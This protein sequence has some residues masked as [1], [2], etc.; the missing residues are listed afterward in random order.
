[1]PLVVLI[2]VSQDQAQELARTLVRERLAGC[3][4]VIP[5]SFSVYRWEGE[6][7]EDTEALL[8]VKT[9][10]GAYPALEARVRELHSYQ[11]PELLALNVDQTPTTF[12]AWLENNVRG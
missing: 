1:M 2:P 10:E 9:T 4:N 6:L 8:L 3:V 5:G 7:A 11:I 12:A